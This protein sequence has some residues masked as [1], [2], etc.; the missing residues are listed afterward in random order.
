MSSVV[1]EN[2]SLCCFLKCCDLKII[3]SKICIFLSSFMKNPDFRLHNYYLSFHTPRPSSSSFCLNHCI[4]VY[5]SI[6]F[7]QILPSIPQ[8]FLPVPFPSLASISSIQF[9]LF[10]LPL[11]PPPLSSIPLPFFPLFSRSLSSIPLPL[12][13]LLSLS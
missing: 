9:P 2:N 3:V 10:P 12:F 5:F 6:P 7:A 8:S 1:K 4:N 11:F 13:P